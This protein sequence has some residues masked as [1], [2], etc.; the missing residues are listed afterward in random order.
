MVEVRKRLILELR[1]FKPPTFWAYELGPLKLI[2]LVAAG[3][4]RWNSQFEAPQ[5]L[6]A[7]IRVCERGRSARHNSSIGD[8]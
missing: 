6:R 7:W 8:R 4:K 1:R 3:I 2:Q 5:G